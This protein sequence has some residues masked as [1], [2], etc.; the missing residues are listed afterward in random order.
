MYNIQC[1]R[2]GLKANG[3]KQLTSLRRE[4]V[5]TYV[6]VVL[7]CVLLISI[8][9]TNLE[10]NSLKHNIRENAETK[11][12]HIHTDINAN[13]N[14]SKT[15]VSTAST[16]IKTQEIKQE[17]TEHFFEDML[18]GEDC[19]PA[20]YYCDLVPYPLGGRFYSSDHWIPDD[21]YDQTSRDWFKGAM[22]L[23]EGEL[24][25]ED[26]YIDVTYGIYVTTISTQAAGGVV[27]L[28]MTLEE[29]S[30][31]VNETK[32]TDSGH[33]FL[34]NKYGE[35]LAGS[36][37]E[38]QGDFFVAYPE[39]LEDKDKLLKGDPL[40][41][42]GKKSGIYAIGRKVSKETG[43]IFI[44]VGPRKEIYSSIYTSIYV[45]L[46]MSALAIILST[47]IGIFLSQSI[48]KP[49]KTVSAEVTKIAL[50]NADL[51][52]RLS[53]KSKNEIGSLVEGFNRFVSTLQG[54]VDQLKGTKQTLVEAESDFQKNI[55]GVSDSIR[56]FNKN[57]ETIATQVDVQAE[58]VQQ[59]SSTIAEIT[60][61]I[62]G[63]K[64]M[65]ETQSAGISEASSAV[66][67]MLGNIGSV[68]Q[69]MEKMA[70]SFKELEKDSETGMQLQK[71][72]TRLV[73]EIAKQSESLKSANVAI[74]DV[75]AQ[76]SLLAMNAAIE[77]AH[78]GEAGKG[79]SVVADEIRKL[80][81]TSS[82]HSKK[83]G[84]ELQNIQEAINS[85]V[86]SSRLSTG[87][88]N[89]VQ[90]QIQQ[91]DILVEQ[92]HSAM[93]EQQEGSTQIMTTLK[94]MNDSTAEV[95]SASQEMTEGSN[96]MLEEIKKLQNATN[97]IKSTMGEMSGSAQTMNQTNESLASISGNVG[98]S[99]R[100]MSDQLDQ[101]KS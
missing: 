76:T 63:L 74:A 16:Y 38:I 3:G 78:A 100:E 69:S 101:F 22:V 45:M 26:P 77:A 58:N 64:R 4:M 28:D 21:D 72:V 34:L 36:D 40:I 75:A 37:A 98:N 73:D 42:T 96:I 10:I 20:L 6:L 67:E 15:I 93:Q 18:M 56:G 49:I 82:S 9:V 90:E 12:D 53:T 47:A 11:L 65:I 71:E 8:P 70:S 14:R 57:I 2:L 66:E 94:M 33:S 50:G 7:L 51:T 79:F 48:V 68:N 23:P 89:Q 41:D 39:L 1:N 35:V 46:I 17:E 60:E 61:N 81:E 5:L 80:S 24:A 92:V 97:A 83:I 52:R 86:E 30:R 54:I 19:F 55:L 62:S 44:S 85:V 29:L 91:T 27:G 95:K 13:I 59:T 25:I 31:T 32:F 87:S 84:T 43:W 88:F 99:I